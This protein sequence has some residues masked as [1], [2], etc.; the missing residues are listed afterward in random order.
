MEFVEIVIPA[1]TIKIETTIDADKL[2]EVSASQYTQTMSGI[3]DL[4]QY[5]SEITLDVSSYKV[6][7]A[8][9]IWMRVTIW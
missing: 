5:A 4:R 1:K 6:G 9:V 8:D 3:T 2:I 7:C